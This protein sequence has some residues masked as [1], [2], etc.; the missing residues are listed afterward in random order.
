M[1][2]ALSTFTDFVASTGPSY[3]TSADQLVNE[4]VKN[5]YIMRRFLKGADKTFVIQGGSSI[6]DALI[7]DEDSTFQQYQP[8]DTF[9]WRNPQ[10]MSTATANWR[11]S[12]DHM[13]WT[14]QEIELN[15]GT[16]MTTEALRGIYKRLKREKEQRMWT[17]MINGW[18]DL[19]WRLPRNSEMESA[20]GLYPYSIP[21]FINEKSNGLYDVSGDSFT[22]LE[23]IDPASKTRWKP[24]QTSFAGGTSDALAW[25]AGVSLLINS[26]DEMFYKIKF[27]TP[28]TKAEYFEDPKLYA[29]FI[30]CS[31]KAL[32]LYQ[33]ALRNSQDHFRGSASPSD[34]AYL[35][36]MYGGI[37]L[38]YVASLDTAALYSTATTGH[39]AE[40]GSTT[41]H[42]TG[43]RYYWINGNYLT[44]V[45]HTSRYMAKKDPMVH[46]NQPFTTVVP[47]DCWWNLFARSRQ[48]HGIIYPSADIT[49]Y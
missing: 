26:F 47:V 36:P 42:H 7:L 6:K 17:S 8:N 35:N 40:D 34:P 37:E 43:P 29:Q 9:T 14:D 16:G 1:G 18:E 28:P 20:S 46:P 49:N 5:S 4:A 13:S 11:F 31:R 45:Y 10:V 3:L 39:V 21:A 30:A 23:G 32:N 12:V 22:T 44:P 25:N 33:R 41:N 15:V 2:S 19:L 48:R 38:M 27:E 24:Q